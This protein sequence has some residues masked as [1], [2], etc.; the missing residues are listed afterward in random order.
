MFNATRSCLF[1][2]IPKTGGTS[3]SRVSRGQKIEG[4][5]IIKHAKP[6]DYAEYFIKRR[7]VFTFTAVRNPYDRLVSAF[8]FNVD[9]GTG[10]HEYLLKGTSVEKSALS[11]NWIRK[12][13][14][15]KKELF[16]EFVRKDLAG[17]LE[18]KDQLF[19]QPQSS[20][21][22]PEIFK[23]DFVVRFERFAT[24]CERLVRKLRKR[25]VG[26]LKLPLQHRREGQSR[27][28]K[29]KIITYHDYYDGETRE[30]VKQLY[31]KDLKRLRYKF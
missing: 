16:G 28:G 26:Y 22:E 29:S 4:H 1:V 30:I 23:Y 9:R 31:K 6:S 18:D 8:W 20:W 15:K 3:I 11:K 17:I 24:D 13:L 2:H 12:G 27:K 5:K 19:T 21:F 25:K 14:A 7:K 10:Q